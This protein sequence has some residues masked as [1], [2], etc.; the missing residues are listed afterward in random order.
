MSLVACTY[1]RLFSMV[2]YWMAPCWVIRT[3][4]YFIISSHKLFRSLSFP[5]SFLNSQ[6]I[7][8]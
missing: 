4:Y 6:D 7:A 8:Y 5:F 2:R 1:S 3:D